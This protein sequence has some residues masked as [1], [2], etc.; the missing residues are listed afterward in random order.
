MERVPAGAQSKRMRLELCFVCCVRRAGTRIVGL[1][2]RPLFCRGG[3]VRKGCR[4]VADIDQTNAASSGQC[5]DNDPFRS[6][7]ED[8][9]FRTLLAA[10][11]LNVSRRIARR[12][13]LSGK[14]QRK[15]ESHN[16]NNSFANHSFSS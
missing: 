9:V 6:W 3:W 2:L 10:Y 8:E 13:S 7:Y 1:R 4:L 12:C 11:E 5:G 14:L 15:C 16:Q